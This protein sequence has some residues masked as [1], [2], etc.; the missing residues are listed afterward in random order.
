M[1]DGKNVYSKKSSKGHCFAFKNTGN[2]FKS[3]NAPVF[4]PVK[5]QTNAHSHTAFARE[6]LRRGSIVL[7]IL[8]C[9]G[10]AVEPFGD[11]ALTL[12]SIF[13]NAL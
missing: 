2:P 6:N 5:L 10:T 7:H 1:N 4:I 11:S 8:R 3:L 9:L 12:L 13:A